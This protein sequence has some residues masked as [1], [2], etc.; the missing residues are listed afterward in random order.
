MTFEASEESEYSGSPVELYTITNGFE[1]VT[2]TSADE[3]KILGATEYEAIPLKRNAVQGGTDFA[4]TVLTFTTTRNVDFFKQ[5]IT[6]PPARVVN[7]TVKQYHDS[8]PDKEQVIIWIGRLV[9]VKNTEKEVIVRC[10]PLHT[11]LRRTGLRRLFQKGCPHVLYGTSCKANINNYNF[12]AD[13]TSVINGID[14]VSPDFVLHGQTYFLGGFLEFVNAIGNTERRF[15]VD[16]NGAN[17]RINLPIV[18]LSSASTVKVYAG[19]NHIIQTC[20]D[21]FSN[22]NNYGGFPYMPEK[23]PFDGTPIF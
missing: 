3:N 1:T 9:D 15:I 4:K 8:D 19:C 11:A 17:I 14:L 22:V 21:K 7:V 13:L 5:Y 12:P 18:G 10:E 16:H 20:S 6:A 23:N 2:Y